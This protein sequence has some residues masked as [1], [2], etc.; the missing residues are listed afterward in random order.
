MYKVVWLPAMFC[1]PKWAA[2]THFLVPNNN[3]SYHKCGVRFQYL[4]YSWM[5]LLSGVKLRSMFVAQNCQSNLLPGQDLNSWVSILNCIQNKLNHLKCSIFGHHRWR[6]TLRADGCTRRVVEIWCTIIFFRD[7]AWVR[8]SLNWCTIISVSICDAPLVFAY[9]VT[10][11]S[12]TGKVRC[13]GT[14]GGRGL[15]S[16][17]GPTLW[18]SCIPLAFT[19]P[20]SSS[21]THPSGTSILFTA[22]KLSQYDRPPSYL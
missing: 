13:G 12:S 17:P 20:T 16:T 6:I 3:F 18:S 11:E 22:S 7:R 19:S 4:S 14:C 21:R 2:A 10:R 15:F 1:H 8:I 5:Y 9:Q